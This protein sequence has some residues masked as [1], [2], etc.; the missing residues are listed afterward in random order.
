MKN[1]AVAGLVYYLRQGMDQTGLELKPFLLTQAG[2][3]LM[4][5]YGYNSTFRV[6]NIINR[7]GHIV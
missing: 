7:Y 3:K 4:D 1:L 2:E 5:K 6:D